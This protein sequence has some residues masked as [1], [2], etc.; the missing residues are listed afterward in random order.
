M[1]K[2]EIDLAH[3]IKHER[4]FMTTCHTITPEDYKRL[5]DTCKRLN[6]SKSDLMRQALTYALDCI[7]EMEATNAKVSTI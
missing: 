6:I 5:G 4:K 3:T 1:K 7:E 2:L